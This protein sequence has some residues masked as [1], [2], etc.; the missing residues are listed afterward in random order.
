MC[1][2]VTLISWQSLP[3]NVDLSDTADGVF[4]LLLGVALLPAGVGMLLSGVASLV[5]KGSVLPQRA[6]T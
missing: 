2:A 6:L 1:L 3:S 4:G 5:S